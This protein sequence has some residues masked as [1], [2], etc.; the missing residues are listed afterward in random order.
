MIASANIPQ[1]AIDHAV[2]DIR[3][4]FR[5]LWSGKRAIAKYHENPIDECEEEEEEERA[6]ILSIK[7][8]Q[9]IPAEVMIFSD[10]MPNS[11]LRGKILDM[12]P[13]WVEGG[14]SDEYFSDMEVF[15]EEWVEHDWLWALLGT[16]ACY[17]SPQYNPELTSEA[18]TIG[19][20]GK[21]RPR[22]SLMTWASKGEW[23]KI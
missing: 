8:E 12:V 21:H 3:D 20:R 15:F 11:Y 7:E 17:Y 23:G 5:R 6:L 13:H 14:M 9:F 16:S 1:V 4:R 18:R 10:S 19:T 22:T 2:A